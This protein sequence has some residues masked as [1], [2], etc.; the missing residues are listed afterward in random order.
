LDCCNF[1]AFSCFT[2]SAQSSSSIGL[3]APKLPLL[4]DLGVLFLRSALVIVISVVLIV[5]LANFSF[6][7]NC[8]ALFLSV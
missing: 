6:I 8:I 4:A 3:S 7:A 2:L 5:E 1:K